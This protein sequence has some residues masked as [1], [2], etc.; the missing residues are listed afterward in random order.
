METPVVEKQCFSLSPH[1]LLIISRPLLQQYY[2]S[3]E[4]LEGTDLIHPSY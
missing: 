3:K 4:A 2:S 1:F